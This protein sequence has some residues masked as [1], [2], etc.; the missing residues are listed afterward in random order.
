MNGGGDLDVLHTPTRLTGWTVIR[1]AHCIFTNLPLHCS[2]FREASTTPGAACLMFN[3]YQRWG[4]KVIKVEE[5]SEREGNIAHHD[6]WGFQSASNKRWTQYVPLL[7]RNDF[8]TYWMW[9]SKQDWVVYEKLTRF[10]KRKHADIFEVDLWL[11][12]QVHL[13]EW[14]HRHG[15]VTLLPFSTPMRVEEGF[16]PVTL[17]FNSTLFLAHLSLDSFHR[18]TPLLLWPAP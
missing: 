11:K 3:Y 5:H 17:L 13:R 8:H 12:S 9:V 7:S 10:V 16:Q 1:D 2:I 6:L 15:S 14:L 18:G 4:W